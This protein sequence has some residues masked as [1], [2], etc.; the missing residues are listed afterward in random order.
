MEFLVS[1]S[2]VFLALHGAPSLAS[3][4]PVYSY[5]SNFTSEYLTLF[6][7]TIGP[8]PPS[9]VLQCT[10]WP[11]VE[12][13]RQLLRIL[14]PDMFIYRPNRPSNYYGYRRVTSRCRTFD[15]CENPA[16]SSTGP[17]DRHAV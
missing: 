2:T 4:G 10:L 6:S 5:D 16:F 12:S 8:E 13:L 9:A 3:N 17:S 7:L 15:P 14:V 11:F 1:H